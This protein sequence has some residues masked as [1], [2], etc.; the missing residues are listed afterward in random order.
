MQIAVIGCGYWGKNLTRNFA[1]LGVLAGV[2][3]ANAD[4]A[5]AV[6]AEYKVPALDLNELLSS[7]IDGVVIA[8]QSPQHYIITKKALLAGKHVFVEKPFTLK[9]TDAKDLLALSQKHQRK[10]MIGHLL[11]YHP[12]FMAL[13]RLVKRDELGQIS[14]IHSSRL[15]FGH[16]KYDENILWDFAPHDLSMILALAGDLPTTVFASGICQVEQGSHDVVNVNLMFNND[17]NAQVFVSRIHPYKEQKLIVVGDRGMAV[18]DDSLPWQEKLK[19]Y[20]HKV[21]SLNGMPQA[22]SAA[23]INI[24]LNALEP[25]KLECQHFVD[26]IANNQQPRTDAKEALGVVQVLHAAQQSLQSQNKVAIAKSDVDSK[27]K[28]H[29]TAVG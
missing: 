9:L 13:N 6:A 25:L 16:F 26:C 7:A 18:F 20:P 11:Q 1:E 23:A 24:A 8:V 28:L 21:E 17:L 27:V 29:E 19:L 3:D 5:R 4:A 15:N 14:Y 2:C 12:G 22:K 10:L